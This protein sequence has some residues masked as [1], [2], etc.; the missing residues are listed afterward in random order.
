MFKSSSGVMDHLS[1]RTGKKTPTARRQ[2]RQ[3]APFD[4][5]CNLIRTVTN[6]S[7]IW[8]GAKKNLCLVFVSIFKSAV[9]MAENDSLISTNTVHVAAR[10]IALPSAKLAGLWKKKDQINKKPFAHIRHCSLRD[11]EHHTPS[12]LVPRSHLAAIEHRG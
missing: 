12:Q 1:Q 9:Y 6:R 3:L 11:T 8:H 5:L 4:S 2:L 7:G 10:I